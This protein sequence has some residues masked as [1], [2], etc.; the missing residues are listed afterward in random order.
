MSKAVKHRTRHPVITKYLC[1]FCKRQVTCNNHAKPFITIT[2]Y[3]KQQFCSGLAEGNIP[4][5]IKDKQ[6]KPGYQLLQLLQYPCL[7]SFQ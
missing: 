3:I 4:Y 5:L 7:I 1:P 6:I 2:Q